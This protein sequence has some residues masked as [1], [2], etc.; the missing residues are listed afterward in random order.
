MLAV[1]AFSSLLIVV[2]VPHYGPSH[3]SLSFADYLL[4]LSSAASARTR[5]LR[6][7]SFKSEKEKEERLR[8]KKKEEE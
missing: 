8:R 7:L 1:V 5:M 4:S 2:V 3:L 6:R